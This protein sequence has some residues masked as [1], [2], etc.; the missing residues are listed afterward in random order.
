V[1]AFA[2]VG[3]T[4]I[5]INTALFLVV[6]ASLPLSIKRGIGIVPELETPGHHEAMARCY[7]EVFGNGPGCMDLAKEDLYKGL[8][9]VVAEMCEV[10]KS[11]PYFHIGCDE[12]NWSGFQLQQVQVPEPSSILLAGLAAM[13]LALVGWRRRQPRAGR[14]HGEDRG[15]TRRTE[16]VSGLDRLAAGRARAGRERAAHRRQSE[17]RARGQYPPCA[18]VGGFHGL[19]RRRS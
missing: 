10:F 17:T 11:S 1:T 16:P 18:L 19:D 9:T 2:Y 13:G 6:F 8:D 15:A 7:P 14:R 4:L 12:A 5:V 3:V